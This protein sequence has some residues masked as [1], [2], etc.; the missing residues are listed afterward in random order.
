VTH[1]R[2]PN[3]ICFSSVE[4]GGKRFVVLLLQGWRVGTRVGGDEGKM[5]CSLQRNH[6]MLKATITM[7]DICRNRNNSYR[8]LIE[9]KLVWQ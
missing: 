4:K 3:N 2:F 6:K 5:M 1:H 7:T 9:C 8:T